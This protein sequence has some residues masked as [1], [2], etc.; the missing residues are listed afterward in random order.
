M[1]VGKWHKNC[2]SPHFPPYGGIEV[3]GLPNSNSRNLPKAGET[4]AAVAK[5]YFMSH[6]FV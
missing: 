4:A 5:R 2:G 6:Q 1:S 3:S